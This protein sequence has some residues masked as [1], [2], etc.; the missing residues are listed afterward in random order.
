VSLTPAASATTRPTARLT[1]L[2]DYLDTLRRLD[3]LRVVRRRVDPELEL[4]AIIRRCYETGAPA[5]LFTDLAGIEPGFRVLGAPAGPSRQHG[6]RYARV[7][8][9]LGLPPTAT[10]QDLV[11]ALSRARSARPLPPSIVP[12]GPC[13]QNVLRGDEVDLRRFPAP[14]LHDG[15]G[16]R[17][18]NTWGS[19]VVR[20]PDGAWTNWA[21]ARVM[22]LDR[23][24]M[25]GTLVPSQHLGMIHQMWRERGEP[26]PFAIVQGAEPAIPV[27]SAMPLPA[28]A[29]EVAH[30]GGYFGRPVELVRCVSGPLA[31]PATAEIVVE[32][33]VAPDELAQE[34]PMGEYAGYIDTA[35]RPQPVYH[36]TAITFRTDPILPVV[37][38][39]EP[40]DEDHTVTGVAASAELLAVLRAHGVPASMAWMPM[41]S[42]CHW[43]VVTVPRDWRDELSC[44]DAELIELVGETVFATRVGACIP[45]VLV[46]HD[47]IDPTDTAEVVWAFATRCHPGTGH[48]SFVDRPAVPLMACLSTADRVS[49]RTT[50]VVYN[51]LFADQ[52]DTIP[53]RSSFRYAYPPAIQR[54]VLAHWASDGLG[55]APKEDPS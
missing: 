11:D 33:V 42:A 30:L 39:G 25:T 8:T 36:V 40:V 24:R 19:V 38:A 21:V 5:P 50:K 3:E 53:R 32:G 47:D 22:V 15:D 45:K 46:M 44:S 9:S 13:Q 49:R 26:M 35:A 41:R 55:P 1:S 2:R 52:T 6:M 28:G 10:G 48:V 17:Y 16:G 27:L 4:G 51:C 7:A 34:G 29:D 37:V 31:V 54:R 43:L 12:E 14:L 20:T 18:F 23:N